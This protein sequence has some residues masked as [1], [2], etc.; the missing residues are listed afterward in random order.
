MKKA[1]LVACLIT[2]ALC[3]S[4]VLSAAEVQG[5]TEVQGVAEETPVAL[6][7][8]VAGETQS[9][10]APAAPAEEVQKSRPTLVEKLKAQEAAAPRT[11]APAWG[12]MVGGLAGVLAL[13][14]GLAWATKKLKMRVP[15]MNTQ[16]RLVEA[17]SLGPREKLCVVVVDGKRLLLGVTQHSITVLNS[18]DDEKKSEEA[19]AMFSEKI[20]KMLQNGTPNGR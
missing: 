17:M 14:L 3:G 16:M 13:I 2:P 5:V 18:S 7:A 1:W 19:E 10:S 4:V 12:S 15:G 6:V 9:T 20:K 8:P 11:P